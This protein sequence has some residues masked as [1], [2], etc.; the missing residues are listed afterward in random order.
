MA[1]QTIT[2]FQVIIP[3]FSLGILLFCISALWRACC[4]IQC[5]PAESVEAGAPYVIHVP[6][7]DFSA[8]PQLAPDFGSPPPY[9]EATL[10]P[11]LFPH[12]DDLPPPYSSIDPFTSDVEPHASAQLQANT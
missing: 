3:L 6:Y 8:R 5:L 2:M 9:S 4:R 10:K 11:H 7:M 1:A 12:P